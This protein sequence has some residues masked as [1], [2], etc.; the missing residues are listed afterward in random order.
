MNI[1]STNLD[2]VFLIRNNCFLDERGVFVKTFHESVFSESK[3]NVN[4][5]ESFYSVS[6]KNV[7]R[8]MHFQK[9]PY[10]HDKLVYVVKGEILDVVVD[11]RAD[12]PTFGKVINEILSDKNAK[13]IYIGKGYAHGFL[14]LSDEAVVIYMTTTTH[15][16]SHD[17]GVKWNSIDFEWPVNTAIVS[18][19]DSSF[20]PINSL[21]IIRSND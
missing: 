11:V 19:R 18:E 13:S 5:K 1:C 7:V 20:L 15:S 16:P 8:G 10:D 21:K 14:T 3:L 17:S 9:P 2:D 6:K 12:S 4:F